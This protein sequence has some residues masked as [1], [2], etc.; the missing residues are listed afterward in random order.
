[1][2]VFTKMKERDALK[3][4]LTQSTA[5][6]SAQ[7][8]ISYTLSYPIQPRKA[9]TIQY[10]VHFGNPAYGRGV[11]TVLSLRSFPT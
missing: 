6:P 1:M 2:S 3:G 10:F 8:L 11:E 4:Q 7:I 9:N 5:M